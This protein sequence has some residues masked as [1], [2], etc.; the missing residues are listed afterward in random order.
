[1]IEVEIKEKV[2]EIVTQDTSSDFESLFLS[3]VDYVASKG[4]SELTAIDMIARAY[5]EIEKEI[6]KEK[7]MA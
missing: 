2:K 5:K 7:E 1:M 3:L 6:E 4:Y